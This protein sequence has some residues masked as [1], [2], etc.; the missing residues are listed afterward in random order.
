MHDLRLAFRTLLRRPG[1]STV[2]LLTLAL[3]IGANTAVFSV[4][5]AVLLAPLP[6]D[7]PDE[8]VILNELSP[9]FSTASVTRYN[10]DDWRARARSFVDIAAFRPLNVTVTGDAGPERVPAK[11]F[12]ATLLPLLG[13]SLHEGRNFSEAEDRPGGEPAVI[14]SSAFAQRRFADDNPIGRSLQID[15]RP[16]TIVGVMPPH[17]ELFAPADVYLP[18]GPWASTLPEDRGWHP[19]I[20]PVAR[21]KPGV[22]VEDARTEMEQISQAL[23][24]Q[25][26]DSN[27]NVRAL[28]TRA[29]DQVVQNV[30]PALLML[31]AA[32]AMVLLIACANVANLLLARAIDRKK[33]TALRIAVGA[34]RSRIVRQFVIESLV[35]SLLGGIAG[36]LVAS[37]SV[38][39]LDQAV[40]TLPRSQ[41]VRMNWG[42]A[43]FALGLSAVTGILFGLAPAIQAIRQPLRQS[44]NEE[45]RSA[46]ASIPQ[47]KTRATL[48][49]VEVALSLVLLVGAGLLLRSFATLTRV[50]P[51]FDAR[52]LLV[53]NLPMAP[54]RFS[55]NVRRT[56]TVQRILDGVRALPGVENAAVTTGLPMSGA[57]A[58]IHF[59]RSAQ[60]PTGPDDYIAAGFRAVTAEYLSTLGVEL[61]K[62]RLLAETDRQGTPLVVVINES[63]ARTYFPDR[64]PLGQRIQLG[65][66][67]DS[68]FP[69][70]EIV[71]I[72]S[73]VKQSFEAGSKAEMFVP[74][75]Q[76]PDAMLVGMYINVA[77][78]VRTTQDPMSLAASV[79]DVI[80]QVNSNQPLVNLR[81]ME[82]AV[83]GTVAQPRL[84]LLLVLVFAGV[85]LALAGIGVYGVMAYT[86]SQRVQ[87]IGIRMAIGASPGQVIGMIVRDGA[88]MALLGIMIGMVA[89][90]MAAAA[91]RSFLFQ[92]EALDPTTFVAAPLLLGAVALLAS[93][94]PAR[95]AAK[96]SPVTA[97]L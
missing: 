95:R 96:V 81:T 42:V 44:L 49:V 8:I 54:N 56:T 19:G 18:F 94:L 2:A 47:T 11:M 68:S 67:P 26:P 57:G 7:R 41:N 91:I 90:A 69:T 84:Q 51:G 40:T 33:E 66:E 31:S 4:T 46:S 83:A 37:W 59:N 29:Q 3:G 80:K 38:S 71:G 27:K 5:R 62:G 14:I 92:I 30:K 63:M 9:Q 65:T 35:L 77:L 32:V 58:T 64:D 76:Y 39:L 23:E 75:A 72:V 82:A 93:Y 1:F 20:F 48:V 13:V 28:I 45:S 85:A 15:D 52:N 50:D 55:D 70:M 16:R 43:Y 73:D 79:R 21:L 34:S 60:P 17:F 22:S 53:V 61:K 74:Y 87:E 25:Y 97:L 36:I 89:A 78:V 6:Y 12:T 88:R 24:A 86:V 10:F